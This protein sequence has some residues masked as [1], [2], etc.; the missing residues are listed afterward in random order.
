M[1]ASVSSSSSQ[2][3]LQQVSGLLVLVATLF[4][5]AAGILEDK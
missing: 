3:S 1:G 4:C 2:F 5:V